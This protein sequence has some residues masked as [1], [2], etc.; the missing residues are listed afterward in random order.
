MYPEWEALFM[1]T[2]YEK[3]CPACGRSA[4]L[5]AKFCSGC[6]HQYRTVF[7]D[8]AGSSD[9]SGA[10]TDG[11]SRGEFSNALLVLVALIP[12]VVILFM[13]LMRPQQSDAVQVIPQT[14][15][16]VVAYQAAA[17]PSTQSVTAGMRPI[18]V[19]QALGRPDSVK[20]VPIGGITTQQWYYS[21]NGHTL[22]VD[23]NGNNV[24]DNWT[25]Y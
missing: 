17:A 8:Q 22:E 19:Q 14:V 2:V 13:F 20:V 6:G 21:R 7:H 24:V 4:P 15:A 9:N 1:E 11:G 12:L 5:A 3:V 16:P 23:F 10:G 25:N 18:D